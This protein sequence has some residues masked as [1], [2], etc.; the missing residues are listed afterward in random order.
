MIR[1]VIGMETEILLK[2]ENNLLERTEYDVLIGYEKSTP[3]KKALKEAVKAKTGANPDLLVI[4]KIEQLSGR[5]QVKIKAYAYKN[6]ET[7]KKLEPLHMLL[8]NGFITK[9]EFAAKKKKKEK[10]KPATPAKK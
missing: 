2:K 8:R 7:M 3:D 9:E 10:K 6:A 1:E 4:K 5:K